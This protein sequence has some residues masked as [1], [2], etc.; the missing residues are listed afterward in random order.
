MEIFDR[1]DRRLLAA[2]VLI[3]SW[4]IPG[5]AQSK[6]DAAG[7]PTKETADARDGQHD[8]D[9]EFG[10]WKVHLRRLLQ[11]LTG[12]DQ[13][14]ELEGTSVVRKVWDG[15]A[16]LGEL[17]VTNPESHI[18]G[19]SLRLYNP[20]AHQWNIYWASSRDGNLGTPPMI[21]QFKNGRGEFYDQE[22]FNGAAIQARFIF[23]EIS[24][25]SFRLEQAFSADGGKTWEANWIAYFSR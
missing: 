24:P 15:R 9:F 7:T 6:S 25:N 21:G 13:W 8:F 19:L 17:E 23:S 1:F 12:S 2:F 11:P 10:S 16:N 20:Q 22:L 5:A 18:E 4:A 3:S 14:V